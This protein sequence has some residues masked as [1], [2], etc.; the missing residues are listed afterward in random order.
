MVNLLPSTCQML[1]N[2][3]IALSV[4]TQLLLNIE[5]LAPREKHLSSLMCHLKIAERK[6]MLFE[7][8]T[9]SYGETIDMI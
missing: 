3:V 5:W 8:A 6:R 1:K 7:E 2:M 4:I 9:F